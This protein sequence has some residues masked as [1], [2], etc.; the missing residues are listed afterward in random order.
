M[1]VY[2]N[3]Y[4]DRQGNMKRA[5]RWYVDLQDHTGRRRRMPAFTDKKQSEA[6]GRQIEKLAGC[7][8]AGESLPVDLQRWLETLPLKM[9]D[10]LN[11]WGLLDGC[12]VAAGR[13]LLDHLE[14]WKLHLVAR[15]SSRVHMTTSVARVQRIATDCRFTFLTDICADAVASFLQRLRAE[16]GL[17]ITTS[18]HYLV[19]LKGFCRWCVREGRLTSDPT[20]HL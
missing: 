10:T 13:S 12:K 17:G 4:R 7:K 2:R 5:A 19:A 14:D 3:T 16:E 11:R 20:A 6:L 18:N 9:R 15:N 1:H 8:V